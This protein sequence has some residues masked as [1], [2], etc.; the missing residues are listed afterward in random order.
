MDGGM[1]GIR[2]ESALIGIKPL[3]RIFVIPVFFMEFQMVKIFGFILLGISCVSF[4]MIPV[5]PFLGFSGIKIA[6]I[7][8]G[9]IITG[10][11]LFY[12]SLFILGRSF[13][14]KIKSFLKFRKAK[15]IN[16]NLPGQPG[17]MSM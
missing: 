8:T 13:Y 5:V 7:T 15:N 3:P 2:F 12:L 11:V 17:Q 1:C 14:D 4:V 16:T 9:L 6:G 10:E